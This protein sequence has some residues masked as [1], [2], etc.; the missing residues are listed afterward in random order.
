MTELEVEPRHW[1]DFTL[2]PLM[3]SVKINGRNLCNALKTMHRN[4]KYLINVSCCC[5][6]H[7]PFCESL[8]YSV[9]EGLE[10]IQINKSNDFKT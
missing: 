8:F 6:Q 4:N 10:P 5:Y 7:R 2:L 3:A 9:L 1:V